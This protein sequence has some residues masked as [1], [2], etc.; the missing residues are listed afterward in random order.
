MTGIMDT[1]NTPFRVISKWTREVSSYKHPDQKEEP[2]SLSGL[3]GSILDHFLDIWQ[4]LLSM[5]DDIM[6]NDT[7]SFRI[8]IKP[9]SAPRHSHVSC[10]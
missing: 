8:F 5:R 7:S 6:S 10:F 3:T 4:A 1:P 2:V 9:L